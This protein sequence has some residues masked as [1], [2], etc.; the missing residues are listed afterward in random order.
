[1]SSKTKT[2]YMTVESFQ[3]K[4]MNNI[5]ENDYSSFNSSHKSEEPIQ[6]DFENVLDYIKRKSLDSVFCYI[7]LKNLKKID[8]EKTLKSA[9]NCLINVDFANANYKDSFQESIPFVFNK[10]NEKRKE[11]TER[12]LNERAL[13]LTK[14]F[15]AFDDYS[16]N[17]KDNLAASMFATEKLSE[18]N[19]FMTNKYAKYKNIKKEVLFLS[20]AL[21]E[22]FDEDK[23]FYKNEYL[24]EQE[25]NPKFKN[26]EKQRSFISEIKDLYG[27][28]YFS[29]EQYEYENIIKNETYR[30]KVKYLFSLIKKECGTFLSLDKNKLFSM[31][32]EVLIEKIENKKSEIVVNN[33]FD[34][35]NVYLDSYLY[36]IDYNNALD[37]DL[38]IS[39]FKKVNH[40]IDSGCNSMFIVYKQTD[41]NYYDKK[42]HLIYDIAQNKY[43][44]TNYDDIH[45]DT[46]FF[47]SEKEIFEYVEKR[48]E[49]HKK[50]REKLKAERRLKLA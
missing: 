13:L 41:E 7:D 4:L 33:T 50:I 32:K 29:L 24:K 11:I 15:L 31:I 14:S 35:K 12:K 25:L 20:F 36:A 10:N 43:K 37:K 21:T 2:L 3:R 49:K 17:K 42:C 27:S 26:E 18:H 16:K 28:S 22:Q 45:N 1:M 30:K 46:L 23:Y 40:H 5:D 47:K 44:Y 38:K 8:N 39:V 9:L 34:F 19:Y 6:K 48:K